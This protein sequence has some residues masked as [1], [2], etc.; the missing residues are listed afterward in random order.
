MPNSNLYHP[1]ELTA[2]ES[3][4]EENISFLGDPSFSQS[5]IDIFIAYAEENAEL[6]NR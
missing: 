2:E 3:I 1:S 5:K 6:V 4:E